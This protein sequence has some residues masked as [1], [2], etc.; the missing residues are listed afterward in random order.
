M[1]TLYIMLEIKTMLRLQQRIERINHKMDAFWERELIDRPI[2]CVTADKTD[3]I[4]RRNFSYLQNVETNQ[5]FNN[6]LIELAATTE[7]TYY[8]GESIPFY[9]IT[10]G[11]DQFAAFFGAELVYDKKINTSWVKEKLLDIY[12][13]GDNVNISQN[14]TYNAYIN[15]TKLFTEFSDD[16][17][18]Q[19]MIDL[20]GNMDCLSALV[21]PMEACLNMIDFPQKVLKALKYITTGY[22]QVMADIFDAMDV[23][24]RGSIGW[25]PLYCSKKS[26][27]LQCD[28]L[29]MLRQEDAKKFVFPFLL[30]E[31]SLLDNSVF[32][33]D[34]KEALIHLDNILAIDEI[35]VIQWVPGAGQPRSYEW[36]QLLQKIQSKG[37]GLW[38]YDWD[39]QH[40]KAFYKQLKPQGLAF[41]LHVNSCDEADEIIEWV[42]RNT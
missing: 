5:D 6:I 7:N 8:A 10:F 13:C 40:I 30:E 15:F 11:P 25:S 33:L 17:Y 21:G 37:K 32:H 38:I 42:S 26:A 27:V 3:F 31:A 39:I 18:M 28:L 1:D 29:C 36:L 14:K 4:N 34:G 41:S 24:R 9:S 16:K 22:K 12:A 35:D 20:H 2:M 19:S 23:K